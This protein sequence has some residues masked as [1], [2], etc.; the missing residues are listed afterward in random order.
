GG[1]L[2]PGETVPVP[3]APHVHLFV[4]LGE[5]SLDGTSLVQGDAARLTHAGTPGFT[6]GEKGAELLVWATE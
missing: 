1:R 5:G 2:Q 4:A 3:D 6:A